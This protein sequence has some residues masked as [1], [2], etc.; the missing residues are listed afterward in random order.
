MT[1]SGQVV[2]TGNGETNDTW[3]YDYGFFLEHRFTIDRQLSFFFGIRGDILRVDFVDPVYPPGFTPVST[4]TTQGLINVNGT[5]SE[6]V[7]I[8]TQFELDAGIFYVQKNW[9]ARL[10]FLISRINR[11]GPRSAQATAR[12]SFILNCLSGCRGQSG[13][14]SSLTPRPRRVLTRHS[15]PGTRH[16]Q[17]HTAPRRNTATTAGKRKTITRRTRCQGA[18]AE[19][20]GR[21]IRGTRRKR[22]TI[23]T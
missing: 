4:S 10:D 19:P 14:S 13:S 21:P 7:V 6:N 17:N 9:E 20:R 15:T 12:T 3:S 11:T 2:N 23:G 8:P 5:Y 22:S 16:S 1:S 18:T